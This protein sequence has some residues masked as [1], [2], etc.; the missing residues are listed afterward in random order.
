MSH[1]R[2]HIHS[3]VPRFLVT[4]TCT[5]IV[6]PPPPRH[7]SSAPLVGL[8]LLSWPMGRTPSHGLGR[9]TRYPTLPGPG[10]GQSNGAR[11]HE[12]STSKS[13][14]G[15]LRVP[16]GPKF[17]LQCSSWHKNRLPGQPEQLAQSA[18][19]WG[20]RKGTTKG[21]GTKCWHKPPGTAGTWGGPSVPAVPADF[22]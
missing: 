22:L 17:R 8:V 2:M 13:D 14:L 19:T 6:A 20:E 12:P 9:T 7:R 21:T 16:A 18:G 5:F 10:G 4:C 3:F 11:R 15:C 1:P